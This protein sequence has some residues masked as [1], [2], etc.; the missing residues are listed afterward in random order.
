MN[1]IVAAVLG[2]AAYA[3]AGRLPVNA[4]QVLITTSEG[5]MERRQ[6]TAVTEMMH[7]VNAGDAK[8]Y[9]RL[10][11]QDAVITIHGSGELKGRG[12]IEQHEVELLREFPGARLAFH[13]IWQKGPL[14]V[15]HYAVNGRTRGGRSMGH[16][17]LLFYR[18]H[19]SGLIEDEHRYMDSLTPM[20]Q[21]GLLGDALPARPLPTLP[22]ELK[23]HVA[24]GSAHE[25]ENVAMVTASFAALDSKDEPAFLSSVAEDAVL[26]ELIDPQPL[27]GKRNV[28]AWFERWTGAVADA[29]FEITSILGIGEFVLVETVVRG[30]LKGPLGRLSAANKE[31][32]VH[33]AA[34]VQVR[35]GKLTRISVFMNGKELAVA[36]GQWPLPVGK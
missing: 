12:A 19:P 29:S 9:A 4:P 27:V 31:F 22:T 1:P 25:N 8:G 17:G 36:V 30:T 7:A 15:V 23:A 16:E 3:A 5:Q 21:L 10:Y 18:F 6:V 32:A 26:D 11:A 24:K 13:A 33:R 2:V 14:A 20:A 35:D 34:I 28:R